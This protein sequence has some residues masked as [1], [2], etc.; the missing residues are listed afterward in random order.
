M[1]RKTVVKYMTEYCDIQDIPKKMKS[2]GLK[3]LLR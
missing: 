2:K 3:I 1:S